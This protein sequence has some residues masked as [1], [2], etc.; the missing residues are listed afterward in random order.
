M[1][2]AASVAH[3]V[4]RPLAANLAREMDDDIGA[5]LLHQTGRHPGL[6]EVQLTPGD[7]RAWRLVVPV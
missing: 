6:A 5:I 7:P 2:L 1:R 3:R 4:D